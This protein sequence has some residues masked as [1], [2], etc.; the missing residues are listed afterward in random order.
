M[1]PLNG[2]ENVKL[3]FEKL[4]T[5]LVSSPILSYPQNEGLFILDTDAS[6]VGMGAVLSQVQMNKKRSY[7]I[8]ANVSQNL[9]GITVSQEESCLP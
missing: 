1:L 5:A 3:H 9:N 2:H 7:A 4:K 8:L 6:N